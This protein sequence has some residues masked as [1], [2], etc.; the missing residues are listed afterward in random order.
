MKIRSLKNI[1]E[2]VYE[3]II[4]G[5]IGYDVI[6]RNVVNELLWLK[7][8]NMVTDIYVRINTEGGSILDGIQICT[9][10]FRLGKSGIKIHTFN[11]GYVISMG[12]PIWFTAPKNRRHCVSYS[13]TMFH[14]PLYGGESM[15]DIQDEN[16]RK[17]CEAF[18][19]TLM[20]IMNVNGGVN[21]EQMAQIMN[22]ETWYNTRSMIN[23][24]WLLE[25]NIEILGVEIE[26]NDKLDIK[27][28]VSLVSNQLQS[29]RISNN[30]KSNNNMENPLKAIAMFLGLNPE[31]SK[32]SIQ[33]EVENLKNGSLKK[34]EDLTKGLESEK[35]ARL[36]LEKVNGELTAKIAVLEESEKTAKEKEAVDFVELA[37]K[38]GKIKAEAKEQSLAL[39][40]ANFEGFKTLM[41]NI[42]MKVEAPNVTLQLS[43][44]KT[45]AVSELG[46]KEEELTFDNL[47]KKNP[48]MLERIQNESPVLFA[49]LLKEYESQNNGGK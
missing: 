44:D 30:F 28:R 34:I 26:V 12:G 3:L 20:E 1:K 14:N 22:D 9:T 23:K 37:I 48:E 36:D 7:D 33:I 17:M 40:K 29:L 49:Q 8:N 42:V 45:K 10:L 39:A 6:G 18:K 32:E 2:K 41:S 27:D 43:A 24:G 16:D 4:Y 25:E 15:E 46:I 47:S 11:D 19:E 38:E 35:K 5:E 13:Q 21:A 31:A